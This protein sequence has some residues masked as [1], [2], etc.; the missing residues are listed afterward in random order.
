MKNGNKRIAVTSLLV[1]LYL[2]SKWMKIDHQELYNFAKW[3]AA[4][5]ANI[6]PTVVGSIDEFI[7]KYIIDLKTSQ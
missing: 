1:F 3:I 5:P 7:G 2:N 4:S 6:M